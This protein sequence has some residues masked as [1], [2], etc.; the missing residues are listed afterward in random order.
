MTHSNRQNGVNSIMLVNLYG[1]I[2]K[3]SKTNWLKYCRDRANESA[4]DI[5]KISKYLGVF[6]DATDWTIEDYAAQLK[7]KQSK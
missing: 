5:E 2:Y 7:N 4:A 1:G 3:I 6:V